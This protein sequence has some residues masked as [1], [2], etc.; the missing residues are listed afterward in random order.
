[1]VKEIKKVSKKSLMIF[2]V[3]YDSSLIFFENV[4]FLSPPTPS[5]FENF[6]NL[7][8]PNKLPA[9]LTAYLTTNTIMYDKVVLRR[10]IFQNIF[11]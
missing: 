7:S 6:F 2:N 4:F 11:I 3:F 1:M 8:Y 9:K 5:I 10:R